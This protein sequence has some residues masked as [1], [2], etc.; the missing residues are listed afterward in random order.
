MKY[1][2]LS[3][4][5][6]LTLQNAGAAETSTP[7]SKE[8]NA[9]NVATTAVPEDLPGKALEGVPIEAIENLPILSKNQLGV[10]FGVAPF[11]PY[12]TGFMASAFYERTLSNSVVWEVLNLGYV[13]TS[14]TNLTTQVAQNYQL[15]IQPVAKLQYYISSNFLFTHTRGKL[16]FLGDL[17]RSFSSAF[18]VGIGFLSTTAANS[19]FGALGLSFEVSSGPTLSWRLEVRDLIATTGDNYAYF[20]IGTSYHF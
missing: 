7:P 2:L 1:F 15:A 3:L 5:S 13:V 8:S 12:Y 4:I 11:N 16:L 10:T 18:I 9:S 6:L 20:T 19:A 17:F 14:D